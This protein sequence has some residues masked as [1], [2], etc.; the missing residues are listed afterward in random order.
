MTFSRPFVRALCI[1]SAIASMPG[2][3]YATVGTSATIEAPQPGMIAEAPD[4]AMEG[5]WWTGKAV[6][7]VFT[8]RGTGA[9]HGPL[10]TRFAYTNAN[11]M[12]ML[13]VMYVTSGENL[14]PGETVGRVYRFSERPKGATHLR[15][16][17]N[18]GGT[19]IRESATD[20]NMIDV[21]RYPVSAFQAIQL[22]D[23]E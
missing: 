18:D 5:A 10:T 9:Y 6:L 14:M 7:Y 21:L 16:V 12:E 8:N 19:S 11:G 15:I 1:L 23:E 3:A 2:A 13:P 22:G 4:L 20:N 17:M